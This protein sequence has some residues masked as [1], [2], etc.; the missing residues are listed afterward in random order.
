VAD[1]RFAAVLG[2]ALLAACSGDV[3]EGDAPV[4]EGSLIACAIGSATEFTRNCSVERAVVDG[5]LTLVINHEDGGFRRLTVMD[6]GSGVTAADGADQA[7]ITVF[8]GEI[9]VAIDGDR[10]L[11][12]AT[13]AG[14]ATS[15]DAPE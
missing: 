11:L 5:V 7:T 1:L 3:P 8:D 15:P 12:P 9:E 10:Y 4:D 13:I 2:L 6:D 14:E